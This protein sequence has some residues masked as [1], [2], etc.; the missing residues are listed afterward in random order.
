MLILVPQF[1]I[2]IL[3]FCKRMSLVFFFFFCR[4]IRKYVEIK[5]T[6]FAT[7]FQLEKYCV[8]LCVCFRRY[9]KK[10]NWHHFSAFRV[11]SSAKI[12]KTWQY[13]ITAIGKLLTARGSAIGITTQV[14]ANPENMHNMSEQFHSKC[15]IC[16]TYM[17]HAKKPKVY[18]WQHYL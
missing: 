2:V 1:Y 9:T 18:T 12:L 13:Q 5:G 14:S 17:Q 7:Y 10:F 15:N 4:N 6:N 11:R 8:Y 16:A 3:W